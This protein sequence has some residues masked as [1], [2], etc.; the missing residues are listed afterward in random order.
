M[1]QAPSDELLNQILLHSTQTILS[2]VD[3]YSGPSLLLLNYL[4]IS[5]YERNQMDE[6]LPFLNK[7]YDMESEDPTTLLNLGTVSYGLGKEED[8]LRWFKKLPEK[9]EQIEKWV[10]EL[11]E[12]ISLKTNPKKWLK[13]LILR[14]EHNVQ[15][16]DSLK[17]IVEFI[18]RDQKTRFSFTEEI[19]IH[20]IIDK[21]TTITLLINAFYENQDLEEVIALL[22]LSE[23]HGADPNEVSKLTKAIRLNYRTL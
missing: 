1:F 16:E 18:N 17:E 22:G 11:E 20:D 12:V 6:V 19:I 4:A 9:N 3:S 10:Y 13:F 14:V 5:N 21:L 2:A 15:R 23:K 8:A 7:A